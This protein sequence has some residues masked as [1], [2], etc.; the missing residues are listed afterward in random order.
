MH[1]YALRVKEEDDLQ[2]AW[3][4]TFEREI[5][6]MQDISDS[7]LLTISLPGFEGEWIIACMPHGS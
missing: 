6:A 2:V 7:A 1:L 5:I 4:S 3:E